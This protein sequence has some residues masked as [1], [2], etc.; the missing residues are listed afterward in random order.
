MIREAGAIAPLIELLRSGP[1]RD[2]AAKAAAAIWSLADECLDNKHAVRELGGIQPLVALLDSGPDNLA[3]EKATGAI[4]FL[5]DECDQNKEAFVQAGAIPPL[6]RLFETKHNPK[7]TLLASIA[8]ARL[9]EL[10]GNQDAVV[11]AG[12][13][14]HLVSHIDNGAD[15]ESEMTLNAGARALP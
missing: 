2:A 8:M 15:P 5:A 4:A 9:A 12:G 11:A 14:K 10:P 3:T 1:S 7:V 6:T 13:I